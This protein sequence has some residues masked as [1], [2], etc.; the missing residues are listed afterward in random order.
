MTREEIAEIER[1]RSEH[2]VRWFLQR[3]V[4][5]FLWSVVGLFYKHKSLELVTGDN[6]KKYENLYMY[7]EDFLFRWADFEKDGKLH[8]KYFPRWF[9]VCSRGFLVSRRSGV[10]EF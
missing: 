10:P 1:W 7:P 3:R 9:G 8:L 4:Y 5:P 6:F 2:R